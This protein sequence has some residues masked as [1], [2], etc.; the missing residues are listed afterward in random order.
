MY[1]KIDMPIELLEDRNECEELEF[2]NGYKVPMLTSAPNFT[3]YRILKHLK[4][5]SILEIGSQNG[6]S[7][8]TMALALHNSAINYNIISID[9]FIETGDNTGLCTL[10]NWYKNVNNSGF[11][12]NIQ[13]IMS[14]SEQVLP[15]INK[16]FDFIFV[17]GSHKYIDVKKDCIM[18]LGLLKEGGYFLVHDYKSYQSVKRACDE[19]IEMFKLPFYINSL[20]KNYRDELCGWAIV[21]KPSKIDFFEEENLA[22]KGLK[23]VEMQEEEFISD[24][25]RR[26]RGCEI[27][28]WGAGE[29][30]KSLLY[31]MKKFN[32]DIN[33]IKGIIDSDEDKS[34]N[35]ID[36]IR[37]LSRKYV[38]NEKKGD[39]SDIIISSACYENEIYDDISDIF[40]DCFVN[41][42]KLY[43]EEIGKVNPI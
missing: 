40:K 15:Y 29:H 6:V 12:D 32:Y 35:E 30:T 1:K 3:L 4:P 20:Q 31:Y 27:Y 42:I 22:A 9:P 39:I 26:I 18:A 16:K 11:T 36:G 2:P 25:K 24:I 34:G 8:V 14:K 7:L 41:I 37:I 19:I 17:D 5:E 28:I 13:L 21:R 23:V 43:D 10:N 33:N 38:I